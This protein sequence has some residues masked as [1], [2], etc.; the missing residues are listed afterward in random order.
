M[1]PRFLSWPPHLMT[2]E[3]SILPNE[4]EG[5]PQ[6]APKSSCCCQDQSGFFGSEMFFLS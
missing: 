2:K 4:K 5:G 1:S 6:A 3:L